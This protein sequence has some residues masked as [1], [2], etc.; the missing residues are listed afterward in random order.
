MEGK[1]LGADRYLGAG[2]GRQR[3]GERTRNTEFTG[4]RRRTPGS[5]R[6][7]GSISRKAREVNVGMRGEGR[8]V[9]VMSRWTDY[10][11]PGESGGRSMCKIYRVELH[12]L[13]IYG[14]GGSSRSEGGETNIQKTVEPC[15]V[16][17]TRNKVN[18]ING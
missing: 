14:G 18:N 16:G 17:E 1:T 2:Q 13:E 3:G 15:G 10:P 11:R 5:G 4:M 6:D 9:G 8:Q 7:L 12:R